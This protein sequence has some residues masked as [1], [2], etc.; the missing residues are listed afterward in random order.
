MISFQEIFHN[1]VVKTLTELRQFAA[2]IG[3][4]ILV[5]ILILAIG[6]FC[7]VLIKKIV[8]KLFKALGLD[9]LSEKT[10]LKHYFERGGIQRGLSSMIGLGFYWLIIL[11][12]LIMVF[13]TLELHAA[14]QFI[15]QIIFYI[16]N[17]IVF[18]IFIILGMFLGRF[19]GK[20]AEKTARLV[21]APFPVILGRAISYAIIGLAVVIALEQLGVNIAIIVQSS[22]VIF[23][24]V[25]LIFSIIFIIGGRDVATGILAQR[26][27]VREYKKGDRIEFDSISGEIEHIDLISTKIKD[28]EKEI[29]IPNSELVRKVIRKTK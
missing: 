19:F 29:I 21:N 15:K 20:L 28:N 8:S 24:V 18:M 17:I 27:L 2:E 12:T 10:G 13:N 25:P 26:F 23:I 1:L 11:S 4:K 3:P 16:P 7:A 5:S 14:S 22:M 9:V 6:W